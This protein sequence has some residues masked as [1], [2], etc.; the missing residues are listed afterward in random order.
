MGKREEKK[1]LTKQKILDVSKKI[2]K[3]V[4][5]EEAKTSLIAKEAGIAEGTIFNY[6]NTKAEILV[7]IV[8]EYL[9]MEDYAFNY[10]LKDHK[11]V[12]A[13]IHRGLEYYLSNVDLV[14]KCF[15]KVI[16]A[17]ITY[18]GNESTQ[19]FNVL[20]MADDK[21]LA[22]L[23]RYLE[24]VYEH[25]CTNEIDVI[26]RIIYS[27]IVFAFLEYVTDEQ[28]TTKTLADNIYRTIE[29]IL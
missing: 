3:E 21:V 19:I 23:R 27:N 11:E 5:Y 22:N 18:K 2:F 16:F 4:G 10:N 25:K 20:K 12:K 6:F 14:D 1:K 28:M 8:D 24:H 29:Y 9:V 15:L 7:T 17:T 26:L 13:E